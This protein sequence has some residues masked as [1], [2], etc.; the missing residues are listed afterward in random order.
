MFHLIDPHFADSCRYQGTSFAFSFVAHFLRNPKQ[1]PVLLSC[2]SYCF[3]CPCPTPQDGP[4]GSF[5]VAAEAT[6]IDCD[7]G[8]TN[9]SPATLFFPSYVRRT[10]GPYETNPR[11]TDFRV[12]ETTHRAISVVQLNS[13]SSS[14]FRRRYGRRPDSLGATLSH[15][16]V[17]GV[18]GWRTLRLA[19]DVRCPYCRMGRDE[20]DCR[21]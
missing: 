20:R 8:Q 18:W 4:A 15:R 21:S 5:S 14:E 16:D 1:E 10:R 13:A 7:Q 2:F 11:S 6:S 17:D 3:L 9:S 19:T 12:F